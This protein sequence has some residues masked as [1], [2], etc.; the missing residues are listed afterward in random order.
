MDGQEGGRLGREPV[1]L[2]EGVV[3]NVVQKES[4]W[5]PAGCVHGGVPVKGKK[6]PS[7]DLVS[8]IV[9]VFGGNA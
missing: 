3:L 9:L 6:S 7:P 4:R 1:G 8:K 5:Y 2:K